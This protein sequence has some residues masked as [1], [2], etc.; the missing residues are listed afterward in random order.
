MRDV[1]LLAMAVALAGSAKAATLT[2]DYAFNAA[3]TS[4]ITDTVGGANGT[5]QGGATVSGGLL[6]L[7]GIDD[8]AQLSSFAVPTTGG[9]YSLCVKYQNHTSQSG[10]VEMVSQGASAGPGFYLGQFRDGNVRLADQFYLGIPAPFPSDGGVHDILLNSD[11]GSTR[12]FVDG[13]LV[14][15]A[16]QY[17]YS[18]FAGTATRF[19]AQFGPHGEY[20]QG[21][22][23]R[24]R[25]YTGLAKVSEARSSPSGIPEPT[26][27]SLMLAGLG[28][29]GGAMRT[30]GK[31]RRPH[32]YVDRSRGSFG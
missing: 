30:R 11:T 25:I 24:V 28:A 20:F 19:G 32:V 22:L 7:D 1:G 3:S 4:V 29:L 15:S 10:I 21:D 26:A 8:Y 13:A 17:L 31:P 23:D 27:W 12:V 18:P 5:L 2:H 14:F 6:H 16:S 9:A